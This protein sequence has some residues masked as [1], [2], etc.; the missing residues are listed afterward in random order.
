MGQPAT[1]NIRGCLRVEERAGGRRV[2][3]G[4]LLKA[5]LT[6]LRVHG[7]RRGRLSPVTLHD[8]ASIVVRLD[9]LLGAGTLDAGD[10]TVV[11][12]AVRV[13]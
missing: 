7:S 2:T 1:R 9:A 13:R 12:R 4:E 3:V 6:R 5:W 8:E 11:H 10:V